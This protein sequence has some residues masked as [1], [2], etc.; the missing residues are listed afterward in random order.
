M[1]AEG[2]LCKKT[3]IYISG[4]DFL[5][6]NSLTLF[7]STVPK[8]KYKEP[9][10]PAGVQCCCVKGEAGLMLHYVNISMLKSHGQEVQSRPHLLSDNLAVIFSSQP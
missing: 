10:N 2:F 8:H 9:G 3:C 5:F 1:H 4:L 6:F 7:L